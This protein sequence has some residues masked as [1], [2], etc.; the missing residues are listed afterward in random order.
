MCGSRKFCQRGS[1]SDV[2]FFFLLV[3]EGKEDPNTTVC[4][5]SSA[6]G[7]PTLNAGLVVCNFPWDP[8]Q[9]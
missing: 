8:E 3:D 6:D 5:P 7:N 4:G 2:F 1:N 9:Y